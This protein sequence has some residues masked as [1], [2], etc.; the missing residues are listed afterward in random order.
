MVLERPWNGPAAT[1]STDVWLTC[2]V[3][4]WAGKRCGLLNTRDPCNAAFVPT[5]V[6]DNG[7]RCAPRSTAE[8]K[9]G[10]LISGNCIFMKRNAKSSVCGCP[11]A[12]SEALGDEPPTM[13]HLS[14]WPR[15]SFRDLKKK[16]PRLS[17]GPKKGRSV[18]VFCP[19]RGWGQRLQQPPVRGSCQQLLSKV[20][21]LSVCPH[22]L[23]ITERF[24]HKIKKKLHE[25]ILPWIKISLPST[26]ACKSNFAHGSLNLS[27][28]LTT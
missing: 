22:I 2:T 20:H 9:F 21:Y 28:F 16:K 5:A 15:C 10:S 24:I 25:T 6:T 4:T 7:A 1:C 18:R 3:L 11:C 19:L 14:P 26:W 27:K 8:H 23:W 17:R 13:L 12:R